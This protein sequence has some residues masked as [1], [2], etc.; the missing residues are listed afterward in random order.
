MKINGQ[1]PGIS[2]NT[3]IGQAAGK[4]GGKAKGA[5][6]AGSQADSVDLSQKAKILKRVNTLIDASPEI[7]EEMVVRLKTDIKSG[8]YRVNV[9]KVAERMLERA[10]RDSLYRE[11]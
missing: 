7:R 5:K 6:R 10:I 8:N 1:K 11:R 3:Q 2:S 4:G 9:E